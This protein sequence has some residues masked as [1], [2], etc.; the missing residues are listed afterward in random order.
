MGGLQTG[1]CLARTVL[2]A[3][4]LFMTWGTLL[5]AYRYL[6]DLLEIVTTDT[7]IPIMLAGMH[8]WFDQQTFTHLLL[9]TN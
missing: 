3:Y 1:V 2:C 6:P 8:K 4:D 7:I 9:V 5:S